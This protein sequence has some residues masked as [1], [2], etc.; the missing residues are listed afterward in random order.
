IEFP[1]KEKARIRVAIIACSG[2]GVND[3]F[4][5]SRLPGND[6]DDARTCICAI[7]CRS[8]SI[9]YLHLFCQVYGIVLHNGHCLAGRSGD[10]DVLLAVVIL[11]RSR[12]LSVAFCNSDESLSWAKVVVACMSSMLP[13]SKE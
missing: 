13:H 8:G 11:M 9:K 3:H 7:Q 5:L 2:T 12:S 4:L 6:I 10:C 1:G